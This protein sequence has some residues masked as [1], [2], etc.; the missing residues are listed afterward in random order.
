MELY[1]KRRRVICEDA[2]AWLR[3]S[4]D[5]LEGSIF[6]GIPDIA[7]VYNFIPSNEIVQR[8]K[9]YEEWFLTVIRLI[10]QRISSG[11]C[12]ILSQTD[13]KIID[14]EGNLVYWVDKAHLCHR[15]ANEFHCQLLWHKIAIDHNSMSTL[16]SSH[17]P[18]YT[19]LLCFGKDFTF[20]ISQF[21]TPDVI[22]RGVMTWDKATGLEACIL[23]IAFLKYV[24]NAP[25]IFNPFCGHGTILAVSDYFGVPSVGIEIMA[26]RARKAQCK[27]VR[28]R[29]NLIPRERL[30]LLVGKGTVSGGQGSLIE[31][32]RESQEPPLSFASYPSPDDGDY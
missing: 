21:L 3:S 13:G 6:C 9:D 11:Q 15:I 29:I 27:D 5:P 18:C 26:K 32:R 19:H 30:Q 22:D 7:D 14:H 12:V 10:F 1:E 16:V 25:C 17:R 2:V 20:P 23:C 31:E 24:V 4:E 28:S 8:A